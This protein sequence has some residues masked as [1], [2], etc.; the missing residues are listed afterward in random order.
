MERDPVKISFNMLCNWPKDKREN[1]LMLIE[2]MYNSNVR[3][4]LEKMIK[5][6]HARRNKK[7]NNKRKS[8]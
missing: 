3:K 2:F 6:E 7:R 4:K 8:V 1:A 5:A